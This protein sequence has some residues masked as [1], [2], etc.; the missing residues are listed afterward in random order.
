VASQTVA[1]G[2]K[3]TQPADPTRTG[4]TFAGWHSDI[5]CSNAW[6]FADDIVT[7]DMM[8]FAKWTIETVTGTVETL[9]ATSLQIYP[10]PFTDAVRITCAA[11]TVET[12]HAL[13]LQ[14]HIINASGVMVHTQT[15]TNPDETIHLEHLPAGV[16]FFV[17]EKD[18]KTKTEKVVK[19]Q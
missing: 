11:A 17:L 7:G 14:L 15:I 10:N 3:A 5:Y 4:Y 16:Y 6:N 18:G 9:R 12:R 19:I 13:S 1:Q 2:G 8:L